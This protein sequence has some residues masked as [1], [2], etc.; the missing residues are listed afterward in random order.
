MTF[1][2]AAL[3]CSHFDGNVAVIKFLDIVECIFKPA[4]G[5]LQMAVVNGGGSAV[6]VHAM[7]QEEQAGFDHQ[8]MGGVALSPMCQHGLD[9]GRYSLVKT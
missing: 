8:F 4:V 7:E 1:R 2:K 9:A 5:E 3:L 6:L